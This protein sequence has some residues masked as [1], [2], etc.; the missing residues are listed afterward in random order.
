MTD[1]QQPDANPRAEPWPIR[2]AAGGCV[3]LMTMAM[4]HATGGVQDP[5]GNTAFGAGLV[6]AVMAFGNI[7]IVALKRHGAARARRSQCPSP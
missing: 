5:I 3:G 2:S 1:Q 4:A 6:V 7:A